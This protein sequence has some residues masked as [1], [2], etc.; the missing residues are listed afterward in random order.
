MATTALLLVVYALFP[1]S[2]I[3]KRGEFV[4]LIV[5]LVVLA[6]V[7]AWQI[8][9]ILRAE[10]PQLRAIEAVTV[11]IPVLIILF[12]LLYLGL[13]QA[14]PENFSE[15]L[16]R[17]GSL[18]FTVTVLATVG[19]GDITARTDTARIVVTIQM[20]LDLAFIALLVRVFIYAAR[21]GSTRR[22]EAR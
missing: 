6:A 1:V 22:R 10:Y 16:T 5:A 11:A 15:P 3:T 19:F 4:H 2:N 9:S 7:I 14:H 20:L 17:A 21:E 12:A 8:R 18:Y 13:A